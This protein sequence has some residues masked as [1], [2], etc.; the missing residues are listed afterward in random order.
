MSADLMQSFASEASRLLAA[1]DAVNGTDY[2]EI[3]V[4]PTVGKISQSTPEAIGVYADNL[5]TE[6]NFGGA[7]I[8]EGNIHFVI[9]SARNSRVL[10]MQGLLSAALDRY[11]GSMPLYDF[12][13]VSGRLT[14][15]QGA[16]LRVFSSAVY[17]VIPE[18]SDDGIHT[19]DLAFRVMYDVERS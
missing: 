14:E 1:H 3:R 10:E 9:S 6:P 13:S 8:S 2:A 7:G 4:R 18:L 12:D 19:S 17:S 16:R 11:A 15:R 5:T